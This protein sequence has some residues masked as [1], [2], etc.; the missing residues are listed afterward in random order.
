MGAYRSRPA[1][2]ELSSVAGNHRRPAAARTR[3]AGQACDEAGSSVAEAGCERGA[4]LAEQVVAIRDAQAPNAGGV[5]VCREESNPAGAQL[6]VGESVDK[7]AVNA[8]DEVIALGLH[9]DRIERIHSHREGYLD[10]GFGAGV[11]I[12]DG[13]AFQSHFGNGTCLEDRNPGGII[14]VEI[15]RAIHEAQALPVD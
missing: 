7:F 13:V 15:H 11:S 1:A 8:G 3:L 12:D 10:P 6:A 14:V 2:N 9:L 4:D 5:S